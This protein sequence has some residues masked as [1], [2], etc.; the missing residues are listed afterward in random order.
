MRLSYAVACCDIKSGFLPAYQGEL[1]EIFKKLAHLGY[2]GVELMIKDP[3]KLNWKEISNLCSENG[4]SVPLICTGEVYDEDGLSL[5]DPDEEIRRK[6][7]QRMRQIIEFAS[8]LKAGV[9]IGRVRGNFCKEVGRNKSLEWALLSFSELASFAEKFGVCLMLEPINRFQCNFINTTQ[10]G[11]EMVKKINSK[12]FQL[13]LDLFHMNIEDVSIE[14]SI[15]DANE[16]VRHIHICDSNRQ[17]PGC[18]HL[19]FPGIIRILK[20]INYQGFLSGEI[21]PIPDD[22][23]AAKLTIEHIT[24]LLSIS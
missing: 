13:M 19:D 21:L 18:G 6:A 16:Y 8:H 5:I 1:D 7:F 23:T 20:R 9:N 3:E 14:S 15:L 24:P 10:E 2:H 11:I 4:L 17:A 12:Y 22:Y